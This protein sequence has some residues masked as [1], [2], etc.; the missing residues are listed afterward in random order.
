M[1]SLRLWTSNRHGYLMSCWRSCGKPPNNELLKPIW[2]KDFKTLQKWWT[3]HTIYCIFI[4]PKALMSLREV[5]GS[6]CHSFC[7]GCMAWLLRRDLRPSDLRLA[8]CAKASRS[9]ER[10]PQRLFESTS[11]ALRE[12]LFVSP[13]AVWY[14]SC[15]SSSVHFK[16]LPFKGPFNIF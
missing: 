13:S 15:L 14:C 3:M 1:C 11:S 6:I 2:I 16:G 8:P 5:L 9:S 10:R 7:P 4:I 12:T